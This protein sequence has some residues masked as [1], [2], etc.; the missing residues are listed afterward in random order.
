MAT[1]ITFLCHTDD[2]AAMVQSTFR[3]MR[4]VGVELYGFENCEIESIKRDRH[5][6]AIPLPRAQRS[7]N[8]RALVFQTLKD[9]PGLCTRLLMATDPIKQSGMIAKNL[10]SALGRGRLLGY[11]VRKEVDGVG[12]WFLSDK[13]MDW[14]PF[15]GHSQKQGASGHHPNSEQPRSLEPIKPAKPGPFRH[16][17]GKQASIFVLEG[18]RNGCLHYNAIRDLLTNSGFPILTAISATTSLVNKGWAER[19]PL[20]RI[21][22]ITRVGRDQLK[23]HSHIEIERTNGSGHHQAV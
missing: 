6:A 20:S 19:E 7:G 4:Y 17:S 8:V 10:Q 9:Y 22:T 15:H 1:K 12:G 23:S 2:A 11:I 14:L 16:P 13:G 21:Y 18:L 5:P 3:G